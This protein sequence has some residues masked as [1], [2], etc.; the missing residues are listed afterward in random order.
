MAITHLPTAADALESND[1]GVVI[2]TGAHEVAN[3]PQIVPPPTDGPSNG[4]GSRKPTKTTSSAFYDLEAEYHLCAELAYQTHAITEAVGIV[5]PADLT[6]SGAR[7]LTALEHL[8]GLGEPFDSLTVA[9]HVGDLSIVGIF[10]THATGAWRGHARHLADLARRRKLWHAGTELAQAATDGADERIE[11]WVGELTT[12]STLSAAIVWEDV[13][14]AMRGEAPPVV[15]QILRRTD[16]Q[17]LIYPGLLHWLMGEPGKGKTWVALYAAAE[18]L[19][20]GHHVLYLDWEGN[21][22]IIGDR[23]GALGVDAHTVGSLLHY[24]R[25][26]CLQRTH[27]AELVRLTTDT[28]TTIAVCDGAAKA[29]ARQGLNEDKAADILAWL[30]LL[31][32]PLTEAGAAVLMLDHVTKDR[33]GRGLW[34]RGSGAKQGEVSGAAWMVKPVHSFSRQQGGRIDLVQAKD[35]EGHVGVDGDVIAQVLLMPDGARLD[36]T[37]KPPPATSGKFRPTHYMELISIAVERLNE[38]GVDPTTNDIL[39]T[40]KGHK[41]HKG[42][43][44]EALLEEGYLSRFAGPN[45]S[46]RHRSERPYRGLDDP[47]SAEYQ[48]LEPG[49]PAEEF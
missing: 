3:E 2:P 49:E 6:D 48:P 14:G 17:A 20:E 38:D 39:R 25:P 5:A 29:I 34:A 12:P 21:R 1:T 47:E 8:H 23:L 13:A 24:W 30:E 19:L 33:D 41:S 31:A 36:I 43:A 22:S 46:L 4:N 35:R 18:Q 28:E 15:P 37:L 9:R 40:V 44:I 10:N 26:P 42:T 27:V 45:R 32:S 7:L 11:H 16:G